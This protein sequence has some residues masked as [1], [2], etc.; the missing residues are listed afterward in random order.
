MSPDKF[1]V[2][3]CPITMSLQFIQQA[4]SSIVL[5]QA[6]RFSIAGPTT[7][8]RMYFRRITPLVHL[9]SSVPNVH[10]LISSP[11]TFLYL[12]SSFVHRALVALSVPSSLSPSSPSLSKAQSRSCTSLSKAQSR[13]CTS[14]N[15]MRLAYLLTVKVTCGFYMCLSPF[16]ALGSWRQE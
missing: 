6:F 7:I 2:L 14:L 8:L 5:S 11:S 1:I 9:N 13:S 10:L 12:P 15:T 3:E 4:A 16:T